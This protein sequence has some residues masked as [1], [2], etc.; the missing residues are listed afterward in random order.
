M[1]MEREVE[2]IKLRWLSRPGEIDDDQVK[3]MRFLV[4]ELEKA[5]DVILYAEGDPGGVALIAR[6]GTSSRRYNPSLW[7]E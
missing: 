3:A 1:S 2:G 5:H 6:A 4:R 7:G